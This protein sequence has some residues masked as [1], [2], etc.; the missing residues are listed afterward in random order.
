MHGTAEREQFKRVPTTIYDDVRY[1]NYPHAPTHPDR[2]ATV[3]T[4]HG[5]EP[6]DP[7]HGR[8]LEIGCGAG[9]NLMAMVTATPGLSA[10]GVDLAAGP[11]ADGQAAATAI[12]LRN[13][14]LRQGDVRELTDGR[15]GA[16]DYIVAHG[17]YGWMPPD[18]NDALLATVAA[19]LAPHGVAYLSYNVHPGGYFRRMLRDAALWHARGISAPLERA[20][21][22]QELYRFLAEQR[23]TSDDP[24]GALLEGELR[25]VADGP[26]DRL[27]HD[28]LSE[29]W[30]PVWFAEFAAH[31]ARHGLD[32]VGEADLTDLRT[33][34]MPEDAEAGV[35]RL[36]DLDRVAYETYTDLL[37]A[38]HFRK[39]VLCS[40]G[41]GVAA[42]PAPEHTA[43]LHWAALPI[44]DPPEL[45]LLATAFA[46]LGRERPRTVAF[47]ELRAGL[48]A[49][50]SALADA[51][52][53]GVR[54]DCL[55]PHAIPL[56]AATDPGARPV[57]SRLAR[58]QA[59]QGVDL[60]SLAYTTVRMEEPAA[61]R[62]VTLL[63]GTRDRDAIRAALRE[64]VDVDL[65]PDDLETNLIELAHLFL[66][67]PTPA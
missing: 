47:E 5:L 65:S 36:A 6:P 43:R 22:A 59:G 58:W 3:A 16:F 39:S 26:L 40:A 35:S 61:R 11:I 1:S 19:S 34:A 63:D 23:A 8:V 66:L 33:A 50:P 52:L 29:F 30:E 14:T 10:L 60:T 45:G 24:Y 67:E 9:V 4:L 54:R 44:A 20:E 17:V 49:D 41:S 27:V 46:R 32:Y 57:A 15:L 53:D 12:G 2:L 51:L 28:D 7:S 42:T 56:R 62:L 18:A 64:D 38:R 13:L 37:T 55:I 21:K 31:A 48:G 25:P